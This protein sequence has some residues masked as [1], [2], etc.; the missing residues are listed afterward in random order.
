MPPEV[1]VGG[2]PARIAAFDFDGT[3]TRGDTL[4]PWLSCLL[5][6][7]RLAWVAGRTAPAVGLAVAR[8]DRDSVKAL[9]LARALAGVEVTAALAAAHRL[10]DGLVHAGLRPDVVARVAA[11]QAAGDRVVVVSASPRLV[12]A[13][14]VARLGIDDVIGTELEEVDGI[15]TGRLVGVNCRGPAKVV[16]LTGWLGAGSQEAGPHGE[17]WAYGDSAGDRELLVWAAQGRLVGREPL[18]PL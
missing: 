10:A 7:R 3:I 4:R 11:H 5:G 16:A 12:V 18:G 8:R 1:V 14:A 6:P 15:F 2:P 17:V 9:L 13:A